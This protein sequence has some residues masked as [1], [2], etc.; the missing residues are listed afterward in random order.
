MIAIIDYGMGNLGSVLNML[1]KV[2][3]ESVITSDPDQIANAEKLILP[4]VGSFDAAMRRIHDVKL[5]NLLNEQVLIKKKPVFGICLGM[6]LLFESSEEGRLPGFGWIKGKVLSF[7]NRIP[8]S[9]KIP[10]MGWNDVSIINQN[11]LTKGFTGDIR[12]YFVHSYF[13]K[14]E[15]GENQMM[16]CDYGLIFDA[17][18]HKTNIYGAQFHPEKSH[19][20]GMQ[21]FKN[22]SE[23]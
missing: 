14:I 23:L 19:R 11:D 9:L 4:G 15:N 10:H 17:A 20:Y 6:H 1:K 21:L 16:T 8:N 5:F 13:V 12:F 7:K 2:G 22:F 3:A 18:V